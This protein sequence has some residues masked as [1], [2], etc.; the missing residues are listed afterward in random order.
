MNVPNFDYLGAVPIDF[1]TLKDKKVNKFT[2]KDSL[3]NKKTKIGV[4]FNTDPSY[5]GGQHWICAFIDL[6]SN[7][8]NFFD[9]YGSNGYYPKELDVF[10]DKLVEEGKSI[11]IDIKVKKNLVR[12]QFKNSECGVYCIKF[13]TDRLSSTFE[14]IVNKSMP[15]DS[16]TVE[17][18]NKFFRTE[19][20]RPKKIL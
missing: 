7:E 10:F 8:I 20:C 2:I 5:K 9:S 3:S 11:G 1:A 18:W 16:V 4:V 12:H 15:D 13:I 17:R 6:E 14:E 19:T